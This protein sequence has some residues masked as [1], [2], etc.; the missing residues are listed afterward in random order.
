MSSFF[1][2][3]FQV[4]RPVCGLFVFIQMQHAKSANQLTGFLSLPEH[5]YLLPTGSLKFM[6]QPRAK[7]TLSGTPALP[8]NTKHLSALFKW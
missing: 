4:L 3:H 6:L 1:I 5:L 2:F 8:V 7:E